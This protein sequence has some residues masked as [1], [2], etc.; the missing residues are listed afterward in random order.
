MILE[1]EIADGGRILVPYQQPGELNLLAHGGSGAV[2]LV[3]H[4][5]ESW[6]VQSNR[7]AHRL[8]HPVTVPII[9]IGSAAT[10]LDAALRIIGEDI[11]ELVLRYFSREIVIEK[12]ALYETV[13][14]ALI[15]CFFRS[16]L[17]INPWQGKL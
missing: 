2:R 4:T 8:R 17:E 10:R 7:A 14:G 15:V 1:Q 13:L 5:A 9:D 12:T 3:Q 11:A 16:G 6:P